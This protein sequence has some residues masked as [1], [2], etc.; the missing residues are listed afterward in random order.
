MTWSKVMNE[1]IKELY[2]QSLQETRLAIR[3]ELG[4]IDEEV[5]NRILEMEFKSNS[6]QRFAELLINHCAKL[7]KDKANAIKNKSEEF[8]VDDDERKTALAIAWQLE[9]LESEIKEQFGLK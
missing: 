2:I 6:T 1:Q 5:I 3:P 4:P 9:V 8:A 7:A